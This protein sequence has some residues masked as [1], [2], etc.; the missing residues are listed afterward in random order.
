M[1]NLDKLTYA[2]NLKNLARVL[3]DPRYSFVHG[4][5]CDEAIVN[6]VF[7]DNEVDF[8]V[9]FAAESHVD[10]S[11]AQPAVFIKTNVL[12]STC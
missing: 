2:G 3:D 12:A 10:R 9:N 5:I 11:I 4:D 8:V 7:G 1:I 6:G